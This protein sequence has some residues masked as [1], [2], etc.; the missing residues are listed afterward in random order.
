L[1]ADQLPQLR[2]RRP[3]AG[4]LAWLDCRAVGS[5]DEPFRRFLDRGRVAVEPGP[6][7]GAPGSG[8]VRLNVGTSAE[9]LADG[10]ARMAAALR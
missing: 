3:Q 8:F 9:L 1:L 6:K 4:Y 5:G 10:V 2:W 7:F